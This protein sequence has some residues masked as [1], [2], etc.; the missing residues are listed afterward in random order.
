MP[1][2]S[3]KGFH[4]RKHM[5][6]PFNALM[7]YERKLAAHTA[8]PSAPKPHR[9]LFVIEAERI[10]SPKAIAY[11]KAQARASET[12]TSSGNGGRNGHGAGKTGHILDNGARLPTA[13]SERSALL[14]EL[15]AS[16]ARSAAIATQLAALN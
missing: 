7:A 9:T 5:Q 4:I 3:N 11:C 13:K 16:H 8:D 12:V 10:L 2:R 6:K 15:A 1:I 14:T